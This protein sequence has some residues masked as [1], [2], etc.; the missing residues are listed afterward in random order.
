[1]PLV[2]PAEEP[3]LPGSPTEAFGSFQDDGPERGL[4][5]VLQR[6][7][8]V[9]GTT[10]WGSGGR[11]VARDLDG[12]L[13]IDLLFAE[14]TKA[15][16]VYLND[17]AGFFTS[18]DPG[19]ALPSET[20]VIAATVAEIDGQGAPD[21]LLSA[22]STVLL[23]IG[24]GEGRFDEPS[25]LFALDEPT[26]VD[27]TAIAVGDV[28]GDGKSD[29]FLSTSGFQIEG[30]EPL[31]LAGAPDV[32]L[33]RRDDGFEQ[34]LV[35]S[36]SPGSSA[37]F[38]TLTDFDKDG[39]LDLYV[40]QDEG[41]Q[42]LMYRSIEGGTE[43]LDV[44]AEVGVDVQM[45]AMGFDSADLNADGRLDYCLS[46]IG[47]PVCL[48]SEGSDGYIDGTTALGLSDPAVGW[49]LVLGDLDNDGFVELLQAS[50]PS[51]EEDSSSRETRPQPNRG[52]RGTPG[53]GFTPLG[54]SVAFNSRDNDLGIVAVDLDEDGA[55]DVV[56]A[57]PGAAPKLWMNRERGAWLEVTVLGLAGSPE[58]FGA[59]VSLR[60]DDRVATREITSIRGPN[61]GAARVHFG[62]GEV[63]EV[64]FVEVRWP[65]G[66][67]VELEGVAT[68]QRL[69]VSHPSLVAR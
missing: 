54:E 69:T 58:S 31:D 28:D 40:P 15:P 47:N 60:F 14:F 32:L 7:E 22:R 59:Q 61:Q 67:S 10:S 57:G 4:N 41:G 3:A 46:D 25:V 6:P 62:L 11:L 64:E 17:G 38:A 18:V 68:R 23:C 50:G 49:G 24:L 51:D 27:I 21:L 20:V 66:A 63:T 30:G 36:T 2:P 26:K 37:L 19:F 1:M 44:S 29:L 12:D 55:L 5:T 33:L 13:D 45:S 53:G 48:L 8:G 52:W 43:L 34:V 39:D 65:D 56:L 16:I 9:L 35:E 42:G